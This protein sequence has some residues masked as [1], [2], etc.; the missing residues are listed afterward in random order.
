[1][2]GSDVRVLVLYSHSL[3]GEGMSRMLADEP[4]LE[5]TAVDLAA[6]VDRDAAIAADP[7]VIVLEQGGSLDPAELLQRTH[8]RVVVGVDITSGEAS[9]LR[10]S[11]IRSQPD[12][13]I[14]AIRQAVGRTPAG[15]RRAAL[16]S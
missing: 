2:T 16:P 6:A 15:H 10:R 5:V 3:L 13:V 11:T 4:G 8:C 1:M 12:A 7:D 9:T 14:D